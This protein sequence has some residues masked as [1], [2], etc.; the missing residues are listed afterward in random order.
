MSQKNGD[1]LVLLSPRKVTVLVDKNNNKSGG[2]NSS[3]SNIRDD[4]TTTRDEFGEALT[5]LLNAGCFHPDSKIRNY[6]TPRSSIAGTTLAVFVGCFFFVC[7]VALV[8]QHICIS[9]TAL[10]SYYILI[11]PILLLGLIHPPPSLTTTLRRIWNAMDQYLLLGREYQLRCT[12]IEFVHLFETTTTANTTNPLLLLFQMCY[13]EEQTILSAST[14]AHHYALQY[15]YSIRTHTTTTRSTNNPNM[16]EDV[17]LRNKHGR[18]LQHSYYHPTGTSLFALLAT[19]YSSPNYYYY[20]NYKAKNNLYVNSSTEEKKDFLG[21]SNR[22]TTRSIADLSTAYENEDEDDDDD[23]ITSISSNERVDSP[24]NKN[25]NKHHRTNKSLCSATKKKNR[26]QESLLLPSPTSS[27]AETQVGHW[28]N[29][30]AK[31]GMRL[32]SNEQVLQDVVVWNE[33]T[34][35]PDTTIPEQSTTAATTTMTLDMEN[36]LSNNNNNVLLPPVH[37]I[38]TSPTAAASRFH[39]TNNASTTKQHH[40]HHPPTDYSAITDMCSPLPHVVIYE[41]EDCETRL[42]EEEDEG[43]QD[44]MNQ[45]QARQLLISSSPCIKRHS[46]SNPTSNT[47]NKSTIIGSSQRHSLAKTSAPSVVTGSTSTAASVVEGFEVDLVDKEALGKQS[48]QPATKRSTLA[49]GVKMVV[50][51]FPEFVTTIPQQPTKVLKTNGF[52]QM[53]TVTSCRRMYVPLSSHNSYNKKKPIL[54]K[55][56]T[57]CLHIGLALDKSYLRNGK[58]AQ[59]SIRIPDE[60]DYMPPH[61]KYPIGSCVATVFGVGVLVGWRVDDDVH[62]VRSFWQCRGTSGTASAYL[63]RD[64]LTGIVEAANGYRVVTPLGKGTVVA[65]VDAGKDFLRGRFFVEVP[66]SGTA[67]PTKTGDAVQVVGFDRSDILS[68]SAPKF[69][70]IIEHIRE[71]AKFQLQLEDYNATMFS[72]QH[73]DQTGAEPNEELS[74]MFA[75]GLEAAISCLFRAV[76]EDPNF[77]KEMNTIVANMIRFFE[78]SETSG[79]NPTNKP[80]VTVYCDSSPSFSINPVT[81]TENP[82][83]FWLL[84]DFVSYLFNN[85]KEP[86]ALA[87]TTDDS[88]VQN[89]SIPTEKVE[90]VWPEALGEGDPNR[91]FGVIRTLIR[92]ATIA[93]VE[94]ESEN[95][96]MLLNSCIELLL[97]ARTILKVRKQNASQTTLENRAKIFQLATTTFDPI[98]DRILRLWGALTK[99]LEKKGRKAK[100]RLSRLANILIRDDIFMNG[101]ENR[102]WSVCISQFE[103][104]VVKARIL[105]APTCAQI[106]ASA[107]IVH[108]SLAPQKNNLNSKSS[109]STGPKG[110]DVFAV[111]A[112]L[113]KWV[114]TPWRTVLQ[115]L[116]RDDVLEAFERVLLR[117]FENKDEECQM[118]NIYA[119]NFHSFRHLIVLKNMQITSN[120][121]HHLLETAYAELMWF[122]SRMQ[123]N[124][125]R[126]F[127]QQICKILGLG[128]IHFEQLKAGDPG[129]WMD[130]LMEEKAVK[131]IQEIDQKIFSMVEKFCLDVKATIEVLPYYSSIDDDIASL[132][133]ELH[134]RSELTQAAEAIVD[135]D[136]FAVY[137]NQKAVIAIDRFFDYLP[138][139]RIPVCKREIT[140]GWLL[141]AHGRDGGDLCLSNFL[142]KRELFSFNLR[143]RPSPNNSVTPHQSKD[144]SSPL[145][146]DCANRIEISILN[147]IQALV[148]NAQKYGCWIEGVDGKCSAGCTFCDETT[149]GGLPLSPVLCTSIQLWRDLEIDDDELMEIAIRDVSYQIEVNTSTKGSAKNKH[150]QNSATSPCRPSTKGSV[151]QLNDTN[152]LSSPLSPQSKSRGSLRFSDSLK[153]PIILSFEVMKLS[154]MLDDFKFRVEPK[155]RQYTIFDLVFEGVGTISISD[156]SLKVSVECRKERRTESDSCTETVVPV[157]QLYELDVGLDDVSLSFRDTGIDWLLNPIL[158][159]LQE[160]ITDV[161]ETTL[162]QQLQNQ[163]QEALIHVN[164]FLEVNPNVLLKL[165]GIEM[166]DLDENLVWV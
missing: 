72:M 132:V 91:A 66:P 15:F 75:S 159:N 101:I 80:E 22:I 108:N 48:T 36:V 26:S 103:S 138:K 166:D 156:L 121:W 154:C 92:A 51:I 42:E 31:I 85:K 112:R 111:F 45:Q 104:A 109:P 96:R 107:L 143:G 16:E 150:K 13:Q 5:R 114:A 79:N 47:T 23:S 35:S 81:S 140:E 56:S 145:F 70:P 157:L 86:E 142:I 158:K 55:K 123:D 33:D 151:Q 38:W 18:Y 77:D 90:I 124:K 116:K 155:T 161:V 83:D 141:T 61:S 9:S 146:K 115:L 148:Q 7:S 11:K 147:D 130:F 3:S 65:Y 95:V 59:M 57:N 127:A 39:K 71:A 46:H 8:V 93:R 21:D 29:L 99:R 20:S 144:L 162:Q 136:R 4:K 30:G 87:T 64:C 98:K 52:F 100:M 135:S 82:S 50:P 149:L 118:L 125:I 133:E 164:S 163:M 62:V 117:V 102:E 139:V 153:E 41:S 32:L 106:H 27:E 76:D 152:S 28:V 74:S 126:Y 49:P 131:I 68:C 6:N 89:I 10:L 25:R 128:I 53:A 84:D 97:F 88:T 58:F 165:L 1:S 67:I 105:D 14:R 24:N 63:Q 94:T 17:W 73:P 160:S 120:L 122:V 40:H 19:Y 78:Q 60:N 137:L 43:R 12:F 134:L 44:D 113:V 110:D 129:D 37:S 119:Y 69:L 34:E 54:H 2:G